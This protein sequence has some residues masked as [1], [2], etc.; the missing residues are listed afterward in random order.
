MKTYI[1]NFIKISIKYAPIEST[2]ILVLCLLSG[3]VPV[4]QVLVTTQFINSIIESLNTGEASVI[5]YRDAFLLML[6]C[7]YDW[8]LDSLLNCISAKAKFNLKS[9]YKGLLLE[10]CAKLKYMYIEDSD[11]WDLISRIIKEPEEIIIRNFM[12]IVQILATAISVV[13]I[14]SV[15]MT[16]VWWV[17]IVIVLSCAPMFYYSIKSGKDNFDATRA[18]SNLERRYGYFSDIL[19]NRENIDERTIFQYSKKINEEY[20]Q[21]YQNAFGI[22]VKR[23][24][25]WFVKTKMGG[26]F[27]A[28]ATLVVIIAL[29]EPTIT[30]T[31][32]V[33][34]FISL[35]NAILSLTDQMSWGL[36]HRIDI[37]VSGREYMKDMEK[38]FNL[39]ETEGAITVP[40]FTSGEVNIEFRNVSFSY[41]GTEAEILKN[42]SFRLETGK[43]YAFVGANGA[44][45]TTIIKLLTGLYDNYNGEIFIND[46]ELRTYLTEEVKGLFSVVYQDF[47]RHEFSVRENIS[48]SDMSIKEDDDLIQKAI[49]STELKKTIDQLPK[50]L[51]TNLGKIHVD[52]VDFSG[53]QWQRLALAR[54]IISKAPVR[55]LDEP[56]AALDPISES[57][58]YEL[59]G[60]ISFSALTIFISH[61]LAS[62]KIADEIIVLNN[63]FVEEKGDFQ[64]LMVKK[65]LYYEMF[66]EQRGWYV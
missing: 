35:V 55:I 30:G 18:V 54:A 53:G 65:G 3:I 60:E 25:K 34:L 62:T 63:G 49:D 19:S 36:S 7:G 23:R 20:Y 66:E 57:R 47:V 15:I 46:Q 44:G 37:V 59:F 28:L 10:K 50:G 43:H 8:M 13:G 56:T 26:V 38:F 5:I 1:G 2:A 41:P 61:R 52:G 11:T 6:F 14:I 4:L 29:L 12:A 51:D 33:G 64:S 45:K 17:A 21:A 22:R 40:S 16:Q 24:F 9:N 39:Q 48:I 31:I 58:I 27:T 42:V 32:T